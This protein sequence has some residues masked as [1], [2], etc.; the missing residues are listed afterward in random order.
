MW[1]MI[2][3]VWEG[4]HPLSPTKNTFPWWLGTSNVDN[5][6]L[7]IQTSAYTQKYQPPHLL[8]LYGNLPGMH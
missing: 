6:L 1:S 4:H 7:I 2:A 8:G 3:P 5:V